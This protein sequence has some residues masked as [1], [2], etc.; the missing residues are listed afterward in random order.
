M[1]SF[2]ANVNLRL[3]PLDIMK[4]VKMPFVIYITE[5]GHMNS[6]ILYWHVNKLRGS[7]QSG[8]VPVKDRNGAAI[9]DKEKVKERWAEHFENV[10]NRNTVAGKE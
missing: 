1:Y 8:L 6:K 2:F 9:I 3:S 10:L 5:Y 4:P 7:S